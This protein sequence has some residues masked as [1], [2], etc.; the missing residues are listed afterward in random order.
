MKVLITG[1]SGLIGRWVGDRLKKEGYQVIGI[2]RVPPHLPIAMDEHIVCDILDRQALISNMR[3]VSPDAL[4]HLAARTD[5][6][7]TA[8]LGGYAA[9]I[10]GVHNVIEAVRQAPAIRR[11]IY[12]S[13]QL[14]CRA[15]HIPA[16]DT[17]YCSDTLYGQS[18]VLTE[19]IVREE[20]GGG[21]EWCLTRPTTVWGPHMNVHYQN[22]LRFI[23]KGLYFHCGRE[24]LYKSYA[25]AGNIAYQYMRLL[26]AEAA[27]IQGKTF[28]LADYKPLS[29]RDYADG[30][31]REMC[32][33]RIP[34]VPL[35]I[36]RLLAVTGDIFNVCG[37][38][39]FPFNSFR[40]NNILT[41]Y[42]F[43]LSSTKAACGPLPFTHEQGIKETA[44]W[45][46]SLKGR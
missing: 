35:A 17:E 44:Q 20:N 14:V 39:R 5:L 38:R 7:E 15:G 22:M 2:D 21:V 25:Y 11:A 1:S 26:T 33:P 29:L 6:N 32:A 28:Y 30:L 45:F 16:S 34:T 24:K 40:L 36:A 12:T 37:F 23:R 10:D 4:I 18:K 19:K 8:N 3:R 42:V 46:L 13:S 27:K 31:A 41:E 43:D 9:N